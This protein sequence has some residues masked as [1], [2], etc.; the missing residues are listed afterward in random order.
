M[1]IIF[2]ISLLCRPTNYTLGIGENRINMLVVDITHSEPW[3]MNTYTVTVY[4]KSIM[5]DELAFVGNKNHQVCSL[6]QVC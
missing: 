1:I 4:R 5:E 6:V 2:F 3:V